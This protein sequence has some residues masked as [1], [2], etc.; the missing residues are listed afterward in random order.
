[1]VEAASDKFKAAFIEFN[2]SMVEEI[3]R[4]T[5]SQTENLKLQAEEY[6]ELSHKFKAKSLVVTT[7]MAEMGDLFKAF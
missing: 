5:Q 7:E 4:Q 6:I 1:M 2:K 3:E